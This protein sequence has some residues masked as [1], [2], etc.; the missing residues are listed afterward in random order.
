MKDEYS[1]K[2][3]SFEPPCGAETIQRM[4]ALLSRIKSQLPELQAVIALTDENWGEEDGVYRFY[5]HSAK[6]F[7]NVRFGRSMQSI[8]KRGF[9]AIQE[10]GGELVPNSEYCQIVK[11]GTQ[12][13]EIRMSATW[14]ENARPILEA[15]W[16]TKYFIQMMIKYGKGL[17]TA[18]TQ[19][20]PSGWA[21][22]LYLYGVA[23]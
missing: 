16:H 12:D 13:Y 14:L 9:Q 5:R 11:E 6:L 10:I 17:E 21:A 3:P 2:V 20:L 23:Q 8:T 18:P 19:Y 22:V 7:S 15:F 1:T 4:N